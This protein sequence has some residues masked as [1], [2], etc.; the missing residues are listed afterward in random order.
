MAAVKS[1]PSA[2]DCELTELGLPPRTAKLLAGTGTI[3]TARDLACLTENQLGR[4]PGIGWWSLRRI[5]RALAAH[6]MTPLSTP[7]P[8]S[9]GPRCPVCGCALETTLRPG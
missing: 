4:I 6:N 7:S 8:K 1:I 9:H 2:P 3:R 5:R